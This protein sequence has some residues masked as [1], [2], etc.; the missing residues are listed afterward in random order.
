MSSDVFFAAM[1]PAMR[2]VPRTSPL[3]TA[4]RSMALSA[5]AFIVMAP[6]ARARR[7]V[8]LFALTSTIRARPA[9]SAWV[10]SFIAADGQKRSFQVRGK[11]PDQLRGDHLW[12]DVPAGICLSA[13]HCV[14]RLARG[15]GRM[16]VLPVQ[17][18]A[19]S[20]AQ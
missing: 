6:V 15:C 4:F 20:L 1:M 2:A 19:N 16:I 9:S 10:K 8:E 12:A 13:Q 17:R 5:S 14:D 11:V 7:S 3:P 18:L